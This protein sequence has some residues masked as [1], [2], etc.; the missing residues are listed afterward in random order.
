MAGVR[1]ACAALNGL[2]CQRRVRTARRRALR[3]LAS[4]TS[5]TA[6]A[7]SRP[8]RARGRG[9]GFECHLVHAPCFRL[10]GAVSST[11]V[12]LDALHVCSP[13][14]DIFRRRLIIYSHTMRLFLASP[15]HSLSFYYH[16]AH[17]LHL[18]TSPA[19]AASP[20]T[21]GVSWARA[22]V[23]EPPELPP[24]SCRWPALGRSGCDGPEH[25]HPRV[26][27]HPAHLASVRGLRGGGWC[28]GCSV[29]TSTR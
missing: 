27:G 11:R 16:C 8:L 5:S 15:F 20:E 13:R 6:G 18:L 14:P 9:R 19:S 3:G 28:V 24:M 2:R 4:S 7:G 26:M 10:A 22:F 12:V 21:S 29:M 17:S 1:C 25:P 23:A